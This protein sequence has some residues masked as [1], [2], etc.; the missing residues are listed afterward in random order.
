M[1]KYELGKGYAPKE[2][3]HNYDFFVTE[4]YQVWNPEFSF[5]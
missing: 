3:K 5:N 1:S 2:L 4:S